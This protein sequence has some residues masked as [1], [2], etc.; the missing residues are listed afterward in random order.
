MPIEARL[1]SDFINL[2]IYQFSLLDIF[3]GMI[4]LSSC[5]LYNFIIYSFHPIKSVAMKFMLV[6]SS[7]RFLENISNIYISK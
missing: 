3:V 5:V 6:L 2:E 7:T 1:Y 4:L